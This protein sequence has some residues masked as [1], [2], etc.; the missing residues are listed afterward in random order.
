MAK[1][2]RT[3]AADRNAIT[4]VKNKWGT[5]LISRYRYDYDPLG[6]RNFVTRGGTAFDANL[7][8]HWDDWTYSGACRRHGGGGS[9]GLTIQSGAFER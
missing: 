7:G 9:G 5:T 2:V 4:W 3:W 1:S 6:R 8:A